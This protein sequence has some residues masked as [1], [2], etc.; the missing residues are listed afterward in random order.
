MGQHKVQ[1][2]SSVYVKLLNQGEINKLSM[3]QF[4]IS[5]KNGEPIDLMIGDKKEKCVVE[6]KN[7]S[8]FSVK[9]KNYRESFK[10]SELLQGTVKILV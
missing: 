9:R 1:S 5:I 7:E 3:A 2:S 6:F 4:I 10:Y 8:Y